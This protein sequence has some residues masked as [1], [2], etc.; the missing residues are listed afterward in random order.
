MTRGITAIPKA[1]WDYRK[2]LGINSQHLDLLATISS[3]YR[4]SEPPVLDMAWI[5]E[6]M[7]RKPD[8]IRKLRSDLTRKGLLKVEPS[9][10]HRRRYDLSPTNRRLESLITA[11]LISNR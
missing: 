1:L 6:A 4:G 9:T 5:T 10:K 3:K 2:L 7:N 8:T 11:E